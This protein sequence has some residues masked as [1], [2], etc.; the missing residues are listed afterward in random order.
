M[1][2]HIALITLL[3]AL[4]GVAGAAPAALARPCAGVSAADGGTA[5][6]AALCLVNQERQR[7]GLAPLRANARLAS[8]ARNHSRDMVRRRYFEHGAFAARILN[9]GFGAGRQVWTMGEN[10]AWGTGELASARQIVIAWMHSPGHRDNILYRGFREA[11][12]GVAPGVPDAEAAGQGG[13]T[14]TLDFGTRR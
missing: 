6:A 4:A 2:R 12:V 1:R 3:V 9:S 11:G 8:A 7:R 14:Y 13:A 5:E 10:I